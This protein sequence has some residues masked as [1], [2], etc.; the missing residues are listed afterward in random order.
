MI[1]ENGAPIQSK[2]KMV[3]LCRC[4]LSDSQPFCDGA[5]F[6]AGFRK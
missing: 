1:D 4:G 5:H 3:S 2:L 6:K